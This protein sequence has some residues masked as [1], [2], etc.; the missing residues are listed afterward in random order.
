MP[1]PRKIKYKTMK[2]KDVTGGAVFMYRQQRWVKGTWP[3]APIIHNASSIGEYKQ[4]NED[5]L[6]KVWS[7]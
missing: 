4:F 6:V 5:T 1:R 7:N 2:F 3:D